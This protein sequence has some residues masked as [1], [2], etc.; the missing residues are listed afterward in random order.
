MTS[1]AA[2]LAAATTA[3]TAYAR[4][5]EERG[6]GPARMREEEARRRACAAA[7]EAD[8]EARVWCNLCRP[9]VIRR[10]HRCGSAGTVGQM[11]DP[12]RS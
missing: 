1:A 5:G 11:Y 2:T 9:F 10:Y 6:S 12:D 8:N 4:G 7:G 3:M